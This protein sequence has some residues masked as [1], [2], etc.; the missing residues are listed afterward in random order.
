LPKD[1][2]FGEPV[3]PER[4][5]RD[6]D[7]PP[8]PQ[9]G[10]GRFRRPR[11]DILS[12][13]EPKL[14]TFCTPDEPL[15]SI[16]VP[17][18]H[19]APQAIVPELTPVVDSPASGHL[20]VPSRERV[21]FR[22][23]E[24]QIRDT[25]SHQTSDWANTQLYGASLS[26][27]SSV[28]SNRSDSSASSCESFL[29]RP[30]LGGSCTSPETEIHDPFLVNASGAK[31]A[32]AASLLGPGATSGVARW[33]SDMDKH[34][35]NTYETYL[36]NPTIT[37]FKTMPGS[38]P[39]LG[40]SHIV[41]RE[42]RKTWPKAGRAYPFSS[43]MA[44]H[45]RKAL[46]RDITPTAGSVNVASGSRSGST[47]PKANTPSLKRGW[48][49]SNA[50]TRKRLKELCKRTT[51][52][53]PHYQRLLQSRSPS[54]D[55]A[56]SFSSG[57]SSSASCAATYAPSSFSRDLGVSLIS[58]SL[59][60]GT[61]ALSAE[62]E[63]R[64]VLSTSSP[65]SV[66][67]LSPELQIQQ[68]TS[69][70]NPSGRRRLGS[71][72]AYHTWGPG[73][74]QGRMYQSTVSSRPETMHATGARLRSPIPDY[75]F[76]GPQKRRA[77]NQLDDEVTP[78]GSTPS[79]D[80]PDLVCGSNPNINQRR[81]RLRNRG[82]TTGALSSRDRLHRLFTPPAQTRPSEDADIGSSSGSA[83]GNLGPAAPLANEIK[84]LGSPFS[85]S[86]K[87]IRNRPSRHGP[88]RSESFAISNFDK[89]SSVCRETSLCPLIP[90][91]EITPS[92]SSES[93]PPLGTEP[94]FGN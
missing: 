77:L 24:A 90:S 44:R 49:R 45:R 69:L 56:A 1:F 27:A 58:T 84:R 8:P 73:N 57:V 74:M 11:V 22:T 59:P 39:P 14:M 65:A 76:A 40:L 17:E 62:S 55:A 13:F 35:W 19:G 36:E 3:T 31:K 93:A 91:D 94:S 30:S 63:P 34:L 60:T 53:A 67:T 66:A 21:E 78:D 33:T 10:S 6:L 43:K 29:S 92:A 64:E 82:A 37:P 46:Y 16:E 9:H 83:T 81:V 54:P 61:P 89:F 70:T 50:A 75:M 15:P 25:T 23:P 86:G 28:C 4:P 12:T 38:I 47:T 87:I 5:A 18:E 52:I 80:F 68:D 48:P 79:Q 26:R 88:S 42:A 71:P 72:F 20:Q 51:V 2:T 7:V 41:A 32:N 85:S